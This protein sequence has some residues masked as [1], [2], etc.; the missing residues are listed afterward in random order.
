[1]FDQKQFKESIKQK[2]FP[3]E[4]WNATFTPTKEQESS[5]QFYRCHTIKVDNS[6][7]PNKKIL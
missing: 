6:I 7:L 3:L 1:M 4:I 5:K 2:G